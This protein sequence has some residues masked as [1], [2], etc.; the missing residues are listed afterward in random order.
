MKD[1]RVNMSGE[2]K[3]SKKTYKRKR[4]NGVWGEPDGSVA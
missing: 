4:V 3:I 1:E 2:K